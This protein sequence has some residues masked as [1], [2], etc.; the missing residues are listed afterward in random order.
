MPCPFLSQNAINQSNSNIRAKA[1]NPSVNWEA[2]KSEVRAALINKKSFACPIAM[3]VAWHSSGTYNKD[4]KT[5][6]SD[7]AT[8][9]FE[10]EISDDANAG[11][12]IVRD[13]LHTVKK[14]H[15]EVSMADLWTLAGVLA[16]EFM[17]GPIVPWNFGRT[18]DPD[19]K[20]CP[21]NG[22]LPD[23]TQGAQHLRDVFYRMGFDD[24]GI[25]ALSGGHTVGRCHLERSGFDGPWTNSALTFDNEY[26][27]N[28]MNLTWEEHT[29]P[30]G[31]L[32]YKDKE[33]GKLMM[34]F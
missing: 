3:R 30:K 11:L 4:D 1:S 2:L 25:V 16:V 23:A 24:E 12:H 15:P 6:G 22:R 9:R 27:K 28:L 17:G 10:P 14:S 20:K 19:G 32:Q 29:T 8:M 18:D 13:M 26:F 33:S 7:G 21:Q 5:G 34:V 31:R